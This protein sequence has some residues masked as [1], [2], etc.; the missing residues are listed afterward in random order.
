MSD[1]WE[2]TNTYTDP[3]TGAQSTST[4]VYEG[5]SQVGSYS[6]QTYT[7]PITGATTTER[8]WTHP[9]GSQTTSRPDR[10]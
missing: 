8:T 1:R 4:D 10:D 6:D 7:D 2:Q 3:I 9:D 5:N